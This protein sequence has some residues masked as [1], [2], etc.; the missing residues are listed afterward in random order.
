MDDLRIKV[1]RLSPPQEDP[2]FP[3]DARPPAL[4]LP[5]TLQKIFVGETF[6]ALVYLS[7]EG[8]V[9]LKNVVLKIDLVDA[10]GSR[11][12][13]FNNTAS[14]V[15]QLAAGKQFATTVHTVLEEEIEYFLT[16]FV[17]W[18]TSAFGD[19]ITMKK[20]Y[21]FPALM[22][23]HVEFAVSQSSSLLLE[24]SLKNNT[25][26]QVMLRNLALENVASGVSVELL[27]TSSQ[28]F[29]QE[30][31]VH[32]F[33]FELA[34]PNPT[35]ARTLLHVEWRTIKGASGVFRQPIQIQPL[36]RSVVDF[37]P[38]NLPPQLPVETPATVL[39]ELTNI[40]AHA[41]TLTLLLE[42]KRM[43]GLVTTG[44][45]RVALGHLQPK[46]KTEVSVCLLP[47]LTGIQPLRGFS[48]LDEV[49][50]NLHHFDGFAEV[51]VF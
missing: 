29:L 22:P 3:S 47:V 51:A 4:L 28:A 9:P 40:C 30:T 43:S 34:S 8:Q 41:L 20:S 38:I 44:P 12:M 6:Q 33:I 48:I 21:R 39:F 42:R 14:P 7:N 50:A 10:K 49:S 45:T 37:R 1:M 23:F 5:T 31:D 46:E 26:S 25:G 18:Y 24:T 19:P 15:L 16:C 32:N 2:S 36:D 27:N 17:S 11:S 35:A 13:V